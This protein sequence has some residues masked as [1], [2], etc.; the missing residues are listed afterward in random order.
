MLTNSEMKAGRF[1]RWA[2][3]RRKLAFIR[4]NIEAGRTVQVANY[5]HAYR[6]T[7]KHV[8][9]VKATKSGLYL[10]RGKRWDCIDGCSIRAF[11]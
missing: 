5:L 11:A 9:M 2:L 4:S 8:E 7:S 1:A 10:Q 6:L 3:A